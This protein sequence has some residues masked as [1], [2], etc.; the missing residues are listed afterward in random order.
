MILYDIQEM[1]IKEKISQFV[2]FF[3]CGIELVN[4]FLH[5]HEEKL[6]GDQKRNS[7]Y[8]RK[9]YKQHS[10]FFLIKTDNT[11]IWNLI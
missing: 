5:H 6:K 10:A 4:E 8:L 7:N 11:Q 9:I 2:V 1:E 3:E